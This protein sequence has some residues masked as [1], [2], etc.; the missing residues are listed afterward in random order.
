[1][2]TNNSA[3]G[4]WELF[5]TIFGVGAV[6]FGIV[7]RLLVKQLPSRKLAHLCDVLGETQSFLGDCVEEGILKECHIRAFQKRLTTLRNRTNEV[8]ATVHAATTWFEDFANWKAGLSSKISR[9]VRDVKKVRYNIST[10]SAREREKRARAEVA[11]GLTNES[12]ASISDEA[13]M[14]PDEE[15][16]TPIPQ[17]RQQLHWSPC[18]VFPWWRASAHDVHPTTGEGT[19]ADLPSYSPHE[20]GHHDVVSSDGPSLQPPLHGMSS[21][22][23][24]SDCT[25]NAP[26]LPSSYTLSSQPSDQPRCKDKPLRTLHRHCA[27]GPVRLGSSYRKQRSR[28]SSGTE[29]LLLSSV[30]LSSIEPLDTDDEE[31]EDFLVQ[32]VQIAH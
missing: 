14:P 8:R 4:G 16:T 19:E 9:L 15:P 2:S 5:T 22:A 10:T 28:A 11:R 17:A 25:S 13:S 21:S 26:S 1:M 12:D 29:V 18:R 31:W 24:A 20:R 3:Y 27:R 32:K 23:T 7:C 30:T 6:V